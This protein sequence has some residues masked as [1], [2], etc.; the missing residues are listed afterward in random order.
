MDVASNPRQGDEVK[1]P[2][3]VERGKFHLSNVIETFEPERKLNTRLCGDI[4][5]WLDGVNLDGG[6]HSGPDEE[7]RGSR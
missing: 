7:W 6:G 1:C 5:V 4:E 3:G 2:E